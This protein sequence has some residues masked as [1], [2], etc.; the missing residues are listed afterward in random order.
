V[1]T[2]PV[3]APARADTGLSSAEAAERAARGLTN[4]ATT[5]GR[6]TV[7]D[8]LR[9][10]V[11]TRFNAIL[12]TL[13]VV[14]LL[15]GEYRDGLFGIVL[16]TNALVGIVQ[17][18]RAKRALDRL[19]VAAAPR[20]R[21]LRDGT[22]VQ[23]ASTDVVLDDVVDVSRGDQLVVDGTVLASTGLLVDESLLS[24][25]SEPVAKHVGDVVLSGS[26]VVAGTGRYVAEAVGDAAYAAR[27]ARE[28]KRFTVVTSELRAGID[29]ILRIATWLLPLAAVLLVVAHRGAGGSLTTRVR[30]SIAGI[31]AM[32]PEGLVLLT[33]VA[34]AVA[35]L[36]LARRR[37][38]VQDLAAVEV[39]A[40]VDVVLVDK[41]GTLTDGAMELEAVEAIDGSPAPPVAVAALGALARIEQRPTGSAAALAAALPEPG[42]R[43]ESVVPF[44]S[45][46]RA[47]GA[48][49]AEHGA[50]RLGAPDG[51]LPVGHPVAARAE[52]LS[53]A[54]LR[55]LLLERE[56]EPV[57]LVALRERV[58]P[59]AAAT[60]AFFTAQ[61]VA[62]KIVSGDHPR[63]AG[64]VGARV[65]LP[66][67]STLDGRQLPD[68]A[69]ELGAAIEGAAVVG[70]VRPEQKR[71]IVR[72]L[73]RRGHVVAMTGDGVNDV[74]ALK[75]A[76]LGVAMGSGSDATRAVAPLVLLDDTFATLPEVVAEGRRVIAN[77]ERVANLFVT[78]SVYAFL[79]AVSVGIAGL[80]FPFFP[81]HLTVVS[82]LTIGVPA[83]FLALA[84]NEHPIRAGFTRRVAAFAV[85]AGAVAAAATFAGYALAGDHAQRPVEQRTLAV[86]VLFLVASWVLLILAR[87]LVPWKAVLLSAMGLAFATAMVTPPVRRFFDLD[88]PDLELTMAGVGVAAT[89]IAVLELGWQLAGWRSRRGDAR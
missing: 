53:A 33:S 15:T 88:L 19:T 13:L 18:L 26:F 87:P 22:V 75:D 34:F 17:E 20:A 86:L 62:V 40:R 38:L 10:N 89:A 49:F 4:V 52:A 24:G 59:D 3:A 27:L 78:K 21:V 55:V 11:L 25:E 74:L 16:V 8:I 85:P 5:T 81:R 68:D 42:W 36:R 80:P 71:D 44:S 63:T 46:T 28:A 12:G 84:P 50:W 6:R 47:S 43:A 72:A 48:V 7:G 23:V 64:A 58:R 30:S 37:V 83:F 31:G 45:S 70:R 57:A 9:A 29:G 32:I 51:L 67:G 61:G 1:G 14:I 69:D 77:V 79:L 56:L 73:Q 60:V 39:L 76:D 41:T 65:G 66:D 54:G 2:A 82:T 35:V